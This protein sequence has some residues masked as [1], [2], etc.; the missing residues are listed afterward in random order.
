MVDRYGQSPNGV[1]DRWMWM[2]MG[3]VGVQTGDRQEMGSRPR[4]MEGSTDV[5]L[6]ARQVRV[7]GWVGWQTNRQTDGCADEGTEPQQ[8]GGQSPDGVGG[9]MGRVPGPDGIEKWVG[10]QTR[11]MGRRIGCEAQQSWIRV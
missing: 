5:Y 6:A 11:W 3:L 1:V 9:R 7:E 8:M 10:W 2:Q 4:Q